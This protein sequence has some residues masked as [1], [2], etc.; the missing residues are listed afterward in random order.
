MSLRQHSG[1]KEF[2]RLLLVQQNG[3]RSV[4]VQVNRLLVKQNYED[5]ILLY[6][7]LNVSFFGE[8]PEWNGDSNR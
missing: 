3:V 7:S 1:E 8:L 5:D 6:Y 4:S 2:Y